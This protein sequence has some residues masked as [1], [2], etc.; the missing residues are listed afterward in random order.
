MSLICGKCG[1]RR[2]EVG[3]GDGTL[4]CTACGN[5]NEPNVDARWPITEKVDAR[6]AAVPSQTGPQS[7]RRGGW[8]PAPASGLN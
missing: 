2:I 4:H 6:P 5:I 7:P 1:S 8:T 3:Q